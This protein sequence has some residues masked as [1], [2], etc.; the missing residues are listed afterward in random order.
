MRISTTG[1]LTLSYL[2]S[3]DS[4]DALSLPNTVGNVILKSANF[5]NWGGGDTV[6]INAA[7]TVT[8]TDVRTHSTS[9]SGLVIDNSYGTGKA[10]TITDYYDDSTT[11]TYALLVNSN[12]AVT[13]TDIDVDGGDFRDYGVWVNNST[14]S[15]TGVTMKTSGLY[16]NNDVTNFQVQGIHILSSGQVTLDELYLDYNPLGLYVDTD[17]GVTVTDSNVQNQSN[18]MQIIA[19]GAVV[20]TNIE[21]RSGSGLGVSIDNSLAA[22]AAAVTISKVW[23]DNNGTGGLRIDSAGAVTITNLY[24]QGQDDSGFALDIE[25]D[26]TVTMNSA[27][28][29]YW[30]WNNLSGS[31]GSVSGGTIHAGGNISL[32]GINAGDNTGGSGLTVISDNGTVTIKNGRFSYNNLNGLTVLAKGAISLTNVDAEYNANGY[33][34]LLDNFSGGTGAVSVT[35]LVSDY[36]RFNHN[37]TIGLDILTKGAVTLNYLLVDENPVGIRF[38]APGNQVGNVSMNYVYVTNSLVASTGYGILFESNGTVTLSNIDIHNNLLGG[39]KIDNSFGTGKAVTLTNIYANGSAGDYGVYVR[40]KGT[41]TTKNIQVDGNGGRQYGIW[42]DNA[43]PGASGGVTMTPASTSDW[44]Y[45]TNFSNIGLNIESNGAVS[46]NG[47]YTHDTLS[48]VRIENR[49]GTGGVTLNNVNSY[50]NDNEGVYIRANGNTALS[51]M[52]VYRNGG[53]L[54]SGIDIQVDGNGTVSLTN[55]SAYE[56]RHHEV[57]VV[58]HRQITAKNLSGTDYTGADTGSGVFLHTDGGGVSILDPVLKDYNGYPVWN[59]MTGELISLDINASGDVILQ[60]VNGYGSDI[61]YGIQVVS[62][63]KVTLTNIIAQNNDD[64]GIYVDAAG[65]ISLT[66]MTAQ[67]N[68]STGAVLYNGHVGSTA[69]VTVA[70]STF[71]YNY[72]SSPNAGLFIQTNGTV[73]LNQV[74]ATVNSG[75]GTYI[76][77][78]TSATATVTVNKSNFNN[79]SVD[80]LFVQNSGNITVNGITANNN[81]GALANGVTLNNSTGTGTVSVLATLGANTFN[82]NRQHGLA[83]TSSNAVVINNATATANMDGVGIGVNTTSAAAGKGTVTVTGAIVKLNEQPGIAINSNGA[84]TLS[85]IECISNGTANPGYAG[86]DIST[87]GGYNV[88]VQN[89]VVSGNGKEGVR[90]D[91]GGAKLTIKKTFYMG[92]GRYVMGT[93]NLV[94][95]TGTL[96]IIP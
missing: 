75:Y 25:T 9:G 46:V 38:P 23:V 10:V 34:A 26:G 7:G 45:A 77:I 49:T 11:G 95:V 63:G 87:T 57:K 54:Q 13:L 76:T 17:G 74:S 89:S 78:P 88:L 21:A 53:A 65:A 82:G 92:N 44:G 1:P 73:L 58:S 93:P 14:G 59:N 94:A 66:G 55:I 30:D 33:G 71:Y 20:I 62:G 6:S 85:S 70:S 91:P 41:I 15:K 12:G 69:G 90:A 50:D 39:V 22:P 84:V 48:G 64:A 16:N 5:Y 79:N 51:N 81:T 43:E 3:R 47:F 61:S 37:D 4:V 67:Y 18:G 42:L 36:I 68:G 72:G 60:R 29:Y 96:E 40:S 56:N 83:I 24:A 28:V 31:E 19:G 52:Q 32:T 86:I 80:G 2:E 8:V 35:G 27:G